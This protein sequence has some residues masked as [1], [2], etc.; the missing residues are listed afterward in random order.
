MGVYRAV[1]GHDGQVIRVTL[2][3]IFFVANVLAPYVVSAKDMM[4]HDQGL[5]EFARD[6]SGN[7][8]VVMEKV[9]RSIA[10]AP[11]KIEEVGFYGSDGDT[12][13]PQR[14]QWLATVSAL[15]DAGHL[16]PSED[17]YSN[18]LVQ[19]LAQN[20]QIDLP[21]L[22]AMIRQFWVDVGDGDSDLSERAFRKMAWETYASATEAVEAQLAAR[23]K[24]LLSIDATD[25]DTMYFAIVDKALADRWRNTGF[26]NFAAYDGGIRDP[27]WDRYWSFLEYAVGSMLD[28]PAKT[29]CPPGTR[30]R[31]AAG[32]LKPYQR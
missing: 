15:A 12:P 30:Q 14:R 29:G 10:K 13:Q 31:K 3:W 9:K 4:V 1:D 22:P 27:M 26:G 25:G 19:V 6:F 23:G 17:K 32:P 18:E 16:T 28:N 2:V 21:L 24:A 5:I 8:P 20:G 11:T 7:D